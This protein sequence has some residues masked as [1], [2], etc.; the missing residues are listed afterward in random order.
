[1][2]EIRIKVPDNLF[3]KLP[4]RQEEI[5]EVLRLGLTLINTPPRKPEKSIVDKTFAAIPI[6]NHKLIEEVIEQ[7]KHEE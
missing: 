6:K 5:Q 4:K 2:A 7:T 3:Q 1:M